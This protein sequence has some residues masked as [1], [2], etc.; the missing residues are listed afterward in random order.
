MVTLTWDALDIEFKLEFLDKVKSAFRKTINKNSKRKKNIFC[1]SIQDDINESSLC[2]LFYSLFLWKKFTSLCHINFYVL[3]QTSNQT[4]IPSNTFLYFNFK[5][6]FKDLPV[7]RS[8]FSKDLMHKG[9]F[10]NL[11]LGLVRRVVQTVLP[12]LNPPV[13]N[14]PDRNIFLA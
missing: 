11:R 13:V 6:Y 9:Y 10:V 8:F 1:V 7:S 2:G 4:L 5:D 12:Q 3:F 14:Y